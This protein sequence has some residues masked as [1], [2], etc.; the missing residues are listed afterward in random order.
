MLKN[1]NLI[2]RR[3]HYRWTA[4]KFK[5]ILGAQ[6][7]LAGRDLY[8]AT[9]AVTR[10]LGFFAPIRRTAPFSR[11]LRPT[12]GYGGSIL[13]RILTGPHWVAFYDMQ[14]DAEDL[15]LPGSSNKDHGGCDRSVEDAYSSTWPYVRFVLYVLDY[16][17]F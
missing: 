16:D 1:F 4:A 8:R 7:H 9:P 11:L 15:I 13:T 12:R 5:H 6:G 17:H 3:H 10:S 2:W 14:G